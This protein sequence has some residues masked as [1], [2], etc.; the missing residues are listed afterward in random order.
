MSRPCLAAEI[1]SWDEEG[2][3]EEATESVLSAVSMHVSVFKTP[4][5][6]KLPVI[7][8]TFHTDPQP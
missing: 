2:R 3:D 6:P 1:R 8:A 5:L 4:F 7:I